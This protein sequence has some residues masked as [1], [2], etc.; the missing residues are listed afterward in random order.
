MKRTVFALILGLIVLLSACDWSDGP[1]STTRPLPQSSLGPNAAENLDNP[2]TSP[3]PSDP[4]NS[5][6][7]ERD[8]PA[9][10]RAE[11]TNMLRDAKELI[12]EGLVDDAKM[13]L[14]DLRSR[15]LTAEE[16]RQVDALQSRLITISD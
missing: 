14:R 5:E 6:E 10:D 11:I 13:L 15:N 4:A 7:T 3:E 16:K 12:D 1:V 9:A 8:N 2:Q